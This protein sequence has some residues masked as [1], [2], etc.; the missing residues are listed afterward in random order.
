M[1]LLRVQQTVQQTL[2]HTSKVDEVL[3][4]YSGAVTATV[5]RLDGTSIA[6]SPFTAAHPSLGIYTFALPAQPQLDTLTVDWTG[7]LAGATVTV[8]DIV[9]IVGGFYFQLAQARDELTLSTTTYPTAALNAKRIEIEQE[10]DRICGQAFVPRFE[11]QILNGTGT[12]RLAIPQN[13]PHRLIRTLRTV[14]IDGTVWT[15]P[16]I[17][18]IRFSQTG[19]L[20]QPD[21]AEW[22]YGFR[23]IIVEYEHGDDFPPEEIRAAT[24]LRLRSKLSMTKSN[25]PR[26][27]LS[28]TVVE[29]GTYRLTT[30]DKQRT[31]DPDVDAV[32]QRY[33]RQQR[34]GVG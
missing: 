33:A 9:E 6:G 29:G 8:R 3:T 16:Q 11:R 31:G 12:W 13:M 5:K 15:T 19:V 20:T 26:N 21:F 7:S 2:I 23:N 28:Y 30:A 22:P 1:S 24:I 27:A 14:T 32:Y 18:T 10:C 17:A 25:V 4:D 34:I